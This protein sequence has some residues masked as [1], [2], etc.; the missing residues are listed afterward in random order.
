[1]DMKDQ[2]YGIE[3]EFT[4]ITRQRAAQG[5]AEYFGTQA[6]NSRHYSLNA[7]NVLDG[8]N[9]T[10]RFIS[11]ASIVAQK[12]EGRRTVSAD[13]DYRVELVSPICTYD[14]I[15]V[16]QELV[17]QLRT[18]GAFASQKCGIHIHVDA[19]DFDAAHL[20]NLINIMAS[21]EDLIYKALQVQVDRQSYCAKADPRFIDEINRV[22][23]RTRDQ[24]MNIWNGNGRAPSQERYHCL[25]LASITKHGTVE[26]RLFNSDINHAGKIK[27][28]IQ[29]SLA[30]TA[31]ALN[32]AG[33]SRTRTQSSNEKYTFRTW[34]LRL[35]MIG[36]EFKTA[37]GH[38]L[39]HLDGC[40][41]WK[42]PAQAI[43]QKERIRQKREKAM[44]E[45]AEQAVSSAVRPA[46]EELEQTDEQE[47]T[48]GASMRMTM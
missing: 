11:D 27:A 48:P 29:L 35:G 5:A 14:D 26:F 42:D 36:D 10:W 40:I 43:A 41:A 7:Y 8:Q 3:V 44:M 30:I 21:K 47:E 38:L 22:R 32:Q 19:S 46:G 45:A 6:G 4:G 13:S 17:R 12:K 18:A 34:L 23:P 33:A 1:M 16:I 9:R 37:R 25:N 24:V 20:K 2:R 39:E 31:Q 28:Y 15:P